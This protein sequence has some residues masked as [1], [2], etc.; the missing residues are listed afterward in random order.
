MTVAFS[1]FGACA[2][3][4]ASFMPLLRLHVMSIS[5]CPSCRNRRGQ[6]FVAAVGQ[7]VGNVGYLSLPCPAC[8]GEAVISRPGPSGVISRDVAEK[9]DRGGGR[10]ERQRRPAAPSCCGGRPL[11]PISWSDTDVRVTGS[12]P[13]SAPPEPR[14]AHD[15]SIGWGVLHGAPLLRMA[16]RNRHIGRAQEHGALAWPARICGGAPRADCARG[17]WGGGL[18]LDTFGGGRMWESVLKGR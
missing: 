2:P 16:I 7:L 6:L 11:G 10:V 8:S 9:R 1:C 12:P 15:Q 13:Y 18:G 4:R 14:A 17:A 5:L 3:P